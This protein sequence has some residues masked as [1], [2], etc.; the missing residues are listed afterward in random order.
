MAAFVSQRQRKT[1]NA[2]VS[3]YYKFL[4]TKVYSLL[5][6]GS[7]IMLMNSLQVVKKKKFSNTILL[8]FNVTD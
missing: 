3:F 1:S 6:I 2:E 7:I 5:I 8:T 4:H